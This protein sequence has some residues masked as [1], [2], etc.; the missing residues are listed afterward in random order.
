MAKITGSQIREFLHVLYIHRVSVSFSNDA[1]VI[2]ENTRHLTIHGI[3]F[4][5]TETGSD[6]PEPP[7]KKMGDGLISN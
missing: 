5:Q 3:S 1:C 6:F 4:S 2:S 7:M